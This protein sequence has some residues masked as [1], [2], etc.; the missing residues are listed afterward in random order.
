M[1]NPRSRPRHGITYKHQYATGTTTTPQPGKN[2]S[3]DN[4]TNSPLSSASKYL[5]RTSL[6]V[7]FL[8]NLQSIS[9]IMSVQAQYP[10]QYHIEKGRMNGTIAGDGTQVMQ[11][12]APG[13]TIRR[14][15]RYCEVI[16]HAN[17]LT[18]RLKGTICV[19]NAITS[20]PPG[21]APSMIDLTLSLDGTYITLLVNTPVAGT[22][23]KQRVI[24]A[25]EHN[26]ST[27]E[28]QTFTMQ[29]QSD[30][31]PTIM[32]FVCIVYNYEGGYSAPSPADAHIRLNRLGAP[33]L[34]D[35][36]VVAKLSAILIGFCINGFVFLI[37]Y[38]YLR[39][40]HGRASRA[41]MRRIANV[42]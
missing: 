10:S 27:D 26:S 7:V 34:S 39:K 23:T 14:W 41:T 21:G 18:V 13:G 4:I 17:N 29:A 40:R 37:L 35:S 32:M 6:H 19:R 22:V 30:T 28:L 1:I 9:A 25:H 36:F 38:T 20:N 42:A 5:L 16:P 33:P 12:D 2:R 31:D 8:M 24:V 15:E 11:N 3:F